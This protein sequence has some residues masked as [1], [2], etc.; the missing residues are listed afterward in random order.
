MSRKKM[1]AYG[2]GGEEYAALSSETVLDAILTSW[3]IPFDRAIGASDHTGAT[4]EAAGKFDHHLSLLIQGV[5]ICR[6]GIDAEPFLAGVAD[7]LV[8]RDVALLVVFKSIQSKLLSNFH[9]APHGPEEWHTGTMEYW[10]EE[11]SLP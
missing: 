11:A 9:L 5:E 6:T 10:A 3:I 1:R 4:F 2:N 8:K 7:F